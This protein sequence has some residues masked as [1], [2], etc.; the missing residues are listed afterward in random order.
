MSQHLIGYQK[1]QYL[2]NIIQDDVSEFKFY[3]G[4][5]IEKGTQNVLNKLFD[6]LSSSNKESLTFYE[7]WAIRT[8]SYGAASAFNT[9]EFKLDESSFRSNPQGF[10]LLNTNDVVSNDYIIHV[11]PTDVY[12]KLLDIHHLFG[13]RIQ[14]KHK[15]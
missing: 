6:V 1:R 5:I 7:E 9:V 13:L 10:Q 3:Q 12:V 14:N 15:Y 2:E 8:G 11:L 4:M